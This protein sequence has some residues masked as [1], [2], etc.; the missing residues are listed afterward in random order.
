MFT[1]TMAISR[2]PIGSIER[3]GGMCMKHSFLAAICLLCTAGISWAMASPLQFPIHGFTIEPLEATGQNAI[4]Q[5]VSLQLPVSDG[6]AP[7][8]NVMI[9][10]FPGTIKDY[11]DMSRGQFRA[12][13]MTIK[14]A[15]IT[16]TS[17]RWTYVG[18]L[19]GRTLK[20]YARALK[21][22]D[23]IYL[24]TATALRRSGRKWAPNS[25]P[26]WTVSRSIPQHRQ[27]GLGPIH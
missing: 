5:P 7:N 15:H 9:Q 10:P 19:K 21:R 4:I 20:F 6:F 12:M 26:L 1:V 2:R 27:A 24:V 23:Q 3:H 13:N 14:D 25:S 18:V 16:T 11:A 22:G 17:I 8:V